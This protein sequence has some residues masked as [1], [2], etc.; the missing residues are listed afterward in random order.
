[1]V[2]LRTQALKDSLSTELHTAKESASILQQQLDKL[3][4]D[5]AVQT[6]A[7]KYGVRKGAV[8]DVLFRARTVFKAKDGQAIAF[9][10]ENPVYAKDGVTL[11]GIDEWLQA[12][13]AAAPHLFE[14][15]RGTSAPGGGA[16]KPV[17]GP[18]TVLRTD[19]N[20][21]LANLEDIA[22]GKIKVR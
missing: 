15:S 9:Q 8:E 7:T 17:A 11:L 16:P 10:G 3:V 4:I 13:P 5:N 20:A 18:G 1:L 21:F 19:P 6:A 14:E 2:A 12:L 22:K